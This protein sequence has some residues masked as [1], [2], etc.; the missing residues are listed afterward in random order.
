MTEAK[1]KVKVM[2]N[3]KEYMVVNMISDL[4]KLTDKKYNEVCEA[5]RKEGPDK[6]FTEALIFCTDSLRKKNGS[7][8]TH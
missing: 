3:P 1:V 6:E 5:L 7:V 2:M 8:N 4:I